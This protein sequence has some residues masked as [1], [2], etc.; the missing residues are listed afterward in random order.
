[1]INLLPPQ[2]L[3]II[4]YSHRRLF[5]TAVYLFICN[6]HMRSDT[7]ADNITAPATVPTTMP[8]SA[9]LLI[10]DFEVEEGITAIEIK[11]ISTNQF[12]PSLNAY[13]NWKA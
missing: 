13:K 6:L 10:P 9:P 11:V 1:M 8:A 7:T 4:R 3:V 5:E 2:I 12:N